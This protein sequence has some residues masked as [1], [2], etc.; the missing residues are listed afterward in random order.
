MSDPTPAA[1]FSIHSS[2]WVPHP[3]YLT[4]DCTCMERQSHLVS[5]PASACL[6]LTRGWA[7]CMDKT[8]SHPC[9]LDKVLGSDGGFGM[10]ASWGHS[11]FKFHTLNFSMECNSHISP[12]LHWRRWEPGNEANGVLRA[13]LMHTYW[14]VIPSLILSHLWGRKLV[15]RL[16]YCIDA[17]Q[18]CEHFTALSHKRMFNGICEGKRT[19]NETR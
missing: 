19:A 16:T 14:I 11:Q 2:N 5:C 17:R 13:W 6:L 3:K 18:M 4:T 1:Q 7:L 12:N 15:Y 10:V 8:K 9:Q